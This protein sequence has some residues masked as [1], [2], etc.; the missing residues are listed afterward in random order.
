MRLAE[1]HRPRRPEVR[2][3]GLTRGQRE[4]KEMT[5]SHLEPTRWS[6]SHAFIHTLACPGASGC[7]LHGRW[8]SRC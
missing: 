5:R 1:G 4:S 6:L 7:L 2:E 8:D 3:S